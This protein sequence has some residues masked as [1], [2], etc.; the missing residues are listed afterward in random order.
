[1]DQRAPYQLDNIIT[2]RAKEESDAPTPLKS[3]SLLVK[4]PFTAQENAIVK[5]LIT[6]FQSECYEVSLCSLGDLPVA[7][8][9]VVSLL[10]IEDASLTF[11]QQ[12]TDTDLKAL[13]RLITHLHGQKILWLT[14]PAQISAKNPYSAMVLGFA[15]TARLELGASFA[16]MEL[17]VSDPAFK[18]SVVQVFAKVLKHGSESIADC[19]FAL[20]NGVVNVPRYITRTIEQVSPPP[21]EDQITHRLFF[22]KPGLLSSLQWQSVAGALRAPLEGADMEVTVR[23]AS[24]SHR[25]S[26]RYRITSLIVHS[27]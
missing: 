6:S 26:F 15:R 5:D 10:D 12:L 23:A 16:T 21:A 3:V 27:G 9:D 7:P 14:G 2:A 24:V 11:F 20:V 22:E 17:E 19:E 8:V 13:I 25:V 18:S 4:D 1:M